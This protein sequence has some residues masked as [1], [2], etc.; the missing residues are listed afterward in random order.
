ML[1]QTYEYETP[2]MDSW[3]IIGLR[4]TKLSYA[5][6][7]RCRVTYT[8]I[9]NINNSSRSHQNSSAIWCMCRQCSPGSS[10]P[11]TQKERAGD[12]A[13]LVHTCQKSL[14]ASNEIQKLGQSLISAVQ[15]LPL[16]CGHLMSH[17]WSLLVHVV[18]CSLKMHLA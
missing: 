3:F 2:I 18:T 15:I 16:M 8:H 7:R 17:A 1:N 6:T 13:M 14:F 5:F 11:P 12:E 9:A 10:F 4:L